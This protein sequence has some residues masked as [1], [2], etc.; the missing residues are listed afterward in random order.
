MKQPYWWFQGAT[1]RELFDRLERHGPD[2]AILTVEQ[3]GDSLYL[4][5]RPKGHA[6]DALLA[7]CDEP[8]NDSRICPPICPE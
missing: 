7:E 2:T 8:L 4:N 5:V 1:V 3:K 6:A